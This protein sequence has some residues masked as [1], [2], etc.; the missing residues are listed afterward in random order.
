MSDQRQFDSDY[1]QILQVNRNCT[2]QDI[3]NQ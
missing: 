1:Y 3:C 2:I